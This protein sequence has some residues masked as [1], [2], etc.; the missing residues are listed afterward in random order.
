MT[1][2]ASRRME[3]KIMSGIPILIVFYI[4]FTSPGFLTFC[5][6]PFLEGF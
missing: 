5:M 6:S 4:E 2:T 1:A 3:Q